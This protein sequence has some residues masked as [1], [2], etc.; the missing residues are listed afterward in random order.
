MDIIGLREIVQAVEHF[1]KG[2]ALE[3]AG[4]FEKHAEE[5]PRARY[6]QGIALWVS[7]DKRVGLDL[8]V[9]AVN[10]QPGI[11]PFQ[12]LEGIEDV[13]NE[14]AAQAE[15]LDE[16]TLS[17]PGRLS[18]K[19]VAME[20]LPEQE[21]EK[22]RQGYIDII[23]SLRCSKR[24]FSVALCDASEAELRAQVAPQPIWHSIDLGGELYLE[25]ARKTSKVLAHEMLQFNLPCVSWKSVLDIG[26]WGG[27]FSFE[28]EHRGAARVRAVDYYS[29]ITDF[30]KLNQW[31]R[32]M[33]EAGKSPDNY[34]PDNWVMDHE[35]LPG[36]MPFDLAREKLGSAVEAT[37]SN[38]MDLNP[39]TFGTSD[40]T[41]FL[42][43]LYHMTNPYEGLQQIYNL[44]Q[45]VAVIETHACHSPNHLEHPFWE[46]Y[47][48]D[49]INKDKTTY[50][51][52][53]R[54]GLVA[55]LEDVG[56]RKIEVVSEP[57]SRL[58]YSHLLQTCRHRLVVHAW[59]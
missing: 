47:S 10:A 52:P 21:A 6:S 17:L 39:L 9:D 29:W 43:V 2:E 1:K 36:R 35:N 45:E 8:I 14:V 31:A 24:D 57:I 49:A 12:P 46:F 38:Y 23:R 59:K 56:F 4:L 16:K 15:T 11:L 18:L 44:T 5:F 7:G 22:A 54:A 13:I 28:C 25:G 19:L 33:R 58:N 32:Q 53:T 20:V 42:G 51:G 30:H 34:H 3:A 50:W 37:T 27:F 41:L 48:G 55:M 26:A 40:I